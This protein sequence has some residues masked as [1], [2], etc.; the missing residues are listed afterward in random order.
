[1]ES[2][3]CRGGAEQMIVADAYLGGV[4]IGAGLGIVIALIAAL[5]SRRSG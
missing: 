2:S 3:P 5:R 4:A 1:M